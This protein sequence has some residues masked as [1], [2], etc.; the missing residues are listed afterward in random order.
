MSDTVA[1][2]GVKGGPAIRP[3]SAM[4]TSM[5][6]SLAGQR[7]VV[8]CGLGVTRGLVDQGMALKDLRTIFISHLHSDHY[9]ELGPLLHT[10]W[11]AGLA[12]P[13]AIYGPSGLADYW[14]YFCA[15]MQFDIDI[16]QED[17]GRPALQSLIQVHTISAGTPVHL[18]EITVSSMVTDHPPLTECFAYRFDS[19]SRSVVFGADTIYCPP[20]ADFAKGADLLVHEAMLEDAVDALIARVGNGDDRLKRHL[21]RAHTMAPDA[22]RTATDAGVKALALNHLIPSD[23]P[24]YTDTHWMGA[25]RPQ[26][27][28]PL[29]IGKDGMIIKLGE[30]E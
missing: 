23:D 16:R 24:A 12:S 30:E 7:I 8:D 28:G 21:L 25:V 2:L 6:L 22:A 26:W 5:L 15:S 3:G 20:L 29:H 11:C 1:L 14:R 27:A 10:A 9:L 4:P 17:E 13:V 19:G 18:E